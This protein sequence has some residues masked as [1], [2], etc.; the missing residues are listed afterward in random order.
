MSCSG[1]ITPSHPRLA[2]STGEPT[3]NSSTDLA[4]IRRP[5]KTVHSVD[6]RRRC[7]CQGPAPWLV[8]ISL[9]EIGGGEHSRQC[10]SRTS[11]KFERDG[12]SPPSAARRDGGPA[13]THRANPWPSP[14]CADRASRTLPQP[15]DRNSASGA[16]RPRAAVRGRGYGG[17]PRGNPPPIAGQGR[18]AGAGGVLRHPWRHTTATLTATDHRQD[19][20]NS[21]ALSRSRMTRDRQVQFCRRAKGGD[22]FRLASEIQATK[23]S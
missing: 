3:D 16:G 15:A 19:T 1:P 4:T 21:R 2:T 12:D 11:A 22:S 9:R 5:P 20:P 8:G 10:S 14:R 7:P 6:G 18:L 17:S 23:R 13:Q